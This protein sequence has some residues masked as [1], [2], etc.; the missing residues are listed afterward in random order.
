MNVRTGL[1]LA[2]LTALF[3]SAGYAMGGTGGMVIA[4]A[5]AL[6]MNVLSYWNSDRIVLRMQGA[7]EIDEPSAPEYYAIVR[8]LAARANLP[9]PRVFIM[10]SAQPNA[11]ATGRSPGRA[12]VAA[13]TG[14]FELLTREEVA[15]VLAH[16][17]AHIK[18][19]DTL[20][21]TVTATI[22]GALGMLANLVQLSVMFGGGRRNGGRGGL[23]GTLL[24]AMVAPLAASLV[25]MAISRSR[26]Y[27]ADRLGAMITGQPLWLASALRK[28]QALARQFPN[29]AA[30][31]SPAM[32]HLYIINPLAGRGMDNLFSTHPRTENRI[33]ALEQLARENKGRA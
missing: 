22:A 1:L 28:I 32:A 8:D 29:E 2:A 19:R 15:G 14:L 6:V 16:E 13:T 12:V 21:M 5:V 18:N 4:F 24:L 10:H 31:R 26:E 3:A 33:A 9:M 17:L 23:L 25:Q 27:E 7:H 11:F 30:E 20:T